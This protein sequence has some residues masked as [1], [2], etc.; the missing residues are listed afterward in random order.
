MPMLGGP[1]DEQAEFRGA[2]PSDCLRTSEALR[3]LLT[4][5]KKTVPPECK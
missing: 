1:C 2:G 3:M 4:D 5:A